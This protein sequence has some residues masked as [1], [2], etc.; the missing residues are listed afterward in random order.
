MYDTPRDD[1]LTQGTIFSCAFAERYKNNPVYGLT[2]T[3]R[4]D[5]AQDKV[6]IY[7]FIPLVRIED[8]ILRDGGELVLGRATKACEGTK[9]SI[10]INAGLSESLL[11][12]KTSQEIVDG[13]LEPRASSEKNFQGYLTKFNNADALT[14]KFNAALDSNDPTRMQEALNDTH[15]KKHIDEIVRDLASH[16]LMGYYLLRHMPDIDGSTDGNYVALLR[17]IHHIPRSTASLIRK[18]ICASDW[19]S[20]ASGKDL[21]CPSFVNQHDYCMPTARLRSPWVEHLMQCWALLFS[22]IGIDEND[23][24]SVRSAISKLGI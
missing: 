20:H 15:I 3:A 2:I 6:P 8:W 1:Q 14:Q 11:R 9:K 12:T 16:K 24:E 4:C 23:T 7:N 18:G 21:H 5:A 19:D 10:I 17:E 22:R 13:H